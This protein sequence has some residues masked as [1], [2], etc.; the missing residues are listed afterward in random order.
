MGQD[1][2][3]RRIPVVGQGEPGTYIVYI[4]F[5]LIFAAFAIV[6][7]DEGFLTVSNLLNIV[8]ETTPV[9][10]MAIGMVFVLSAGEI[11]VSI[12]SVVAI[13][14]LLAAY[15]AVAHLAPG[16]V[17]VGRQPQLTTG[18]L[19]PATVS[20][21]VAVLQQ[22]PTAPAFLLM[23]DPQQ[24]TITIRRLTAAP[25]SG[26]SYELWLNSNKLT[27]PA[28]LGPVGNSEVTTRSIPQNIDVETM[29]SATYS[30]SLEP[31]GG[32]ATGAPS[33]PTL[34]KG[35]MIETAPGSSG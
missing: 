16:L 4:G 17:S 15:I 27:T 1:T 28:S 20:Q 32:S 26:R 25:D 23:L 18:A 35:R 19:K 21:L 31:S 14:A 2:R 12:G 9:T 24:R 10:V 5:L 6:L 30:V 7:K 34:F 22:E 8:K 33:G 11:D 29:R 3:F 13:A